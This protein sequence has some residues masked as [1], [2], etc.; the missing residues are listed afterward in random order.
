MKVSTKRN[1]NS[2]NT[3]IKAVEIFNTL[4]KSVKHVDANN[5]DVSIQVN[6]LSSGI[7]FAKIYDTNGQ[8]NTIKL[9]KK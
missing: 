6:D 5:S 8:F 7:Y 4:G 9:I 3:Q 1:T 2:A